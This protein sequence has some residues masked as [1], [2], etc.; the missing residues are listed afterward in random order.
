MAGQKGAD[1]PCDVFKGQ[2]I[3][4]HDPTG[5]IPV[6]T[7]DGCS[8]CAWPGIRE[9]LQRAPGGGTQVQTPSYLCQ[10]DLHNTFLPST[11]NFARGQP[12]ASRGSW[13]GSKVRIRGRSPPPLLRAFLQARHPGPTVLGLPTHLSSASDLPDGV[14][15]HY[16]HLHIPEAGL[17]EQSCRPL[18]EGSGVTRF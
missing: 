6:C 18:A 11:S 17:K 14:N 3:A 12:Q 4:E 5:E 2:C 15:S 13:D 10:C 8:R 16:M 1:Q 7:G 9:R